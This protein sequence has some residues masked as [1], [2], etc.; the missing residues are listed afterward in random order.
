[1]KKSETIIHYLIDE[2]F[3]VTNIAS[4]IEKKLMDPDSQVQFSHLF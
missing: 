1:M 3:L 2:C 4:Y